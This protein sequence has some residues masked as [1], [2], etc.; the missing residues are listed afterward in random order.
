MLLPY[1]YKEMLEI[2]DKYIS[3][4]KLGKASGEGFYKYNEKWLKFNHF[5]K[6]I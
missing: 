5:F 4:G 3:E 2:V 6:F 1:S